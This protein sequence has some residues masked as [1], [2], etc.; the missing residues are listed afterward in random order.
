M[1]I[2]DL[3][4][5]EEL[6]KLEKFFETGEIEESKPTEI[7]PEKGELIPLDEEQV[8]GP[9]SSELIDRPTKV[10]EITQEEEI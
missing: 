5:I 10:K 2:T 6:E 7:I 1:F 4:D 8:T 9:T 3:I